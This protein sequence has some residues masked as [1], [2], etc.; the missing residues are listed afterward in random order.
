MPD[1][2]ARRTST[3][4]TQGC[5]NIV[6]YLDPD[7]GKNGESERDEECGGGAKATTDPRREPFCSHYRRPKEM[8]SEAG[9]MLKA[10][11]ATQLKSLRGKPGCEKVDVEGE[12]V[13]KDEGFF[14]LK[15]EATGLLDSGASH[16]LR[17]ETNGELKTCSPVVVTLAGDGTKVLAQNQY[18]TIVIPENQA[19]KVQPIVP[20]GALIADLGCT[21]QW[22]RQGLKLTHPR[23]GRIK[24]SM[25][26]RCRSSQSRM[27]WS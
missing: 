6:S 8:L 11:T 7:F 19:E 5:T 2:E 10:L 3:N 20:L 16:P 17:P 1:K 14:D 27:P 23:H 26:G 21:L 15:G 18:G 13:E 12:T 24:V 25:R 4:I 9:K 22:S